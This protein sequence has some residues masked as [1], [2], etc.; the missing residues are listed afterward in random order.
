MFFCLVWLPCL[1]WF[2]PCAPS[3]EVVTFSLAPSW[4]PLGGQVFVGFP[5][6][7]AWVVCFGV[8]PFLTPGCLW[9]AVGLFVP[10]G[11]RAPWASRRHGVVSCGRCCWRGRFWLLALLLLL[12]QLLCAVYLGA[13]QIKVHTLTIYSRGC[14]ARLESVGHLLD[15]KRQNS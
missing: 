3:L 1:L 15:F 12:P 11:G 5:L 8:P 13:V 6:G 9:F 4:G 10:G 14:F 7:L 2:R